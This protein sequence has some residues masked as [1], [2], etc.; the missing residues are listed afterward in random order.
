MPLLR[1]K[2]C[3]IEQIS[4]GGFSNVAPLIQHCVAKYDNG[5]KIPRIPDLAC[6]YQRMNRK[7]LDTAESM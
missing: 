1:G 6:Y 4:D 2:W 5:D 7:D 3:Q